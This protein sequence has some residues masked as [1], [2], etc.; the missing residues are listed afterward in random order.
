MLERQEIHCHNCN[1]YVQFNLDIEING[2]HVLKCP[3][4][5]HEHCRVVKD[6][7][8]TGDRWD[9]RNGPIIPVSTSTITYTTTST[10]VVYTNCSTTSG[11]SGLYTYMAWQNM[12]LAC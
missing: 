8:I 1:K 6:G 10:Y 12:V 2:N 7:K 4:C 5:G 9:Q 3:V 11:T